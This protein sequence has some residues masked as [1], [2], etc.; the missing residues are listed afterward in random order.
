M[1]E[2]DYCTL[3]LG[4]QVRSVGRSVVSG[5]I[6]I[7]QSNLKASLLLQT[8]THIQDYSELSNESYDSFLAPFVAHRTPNSTVFCYIAYVCTWFKQ[9]TTLLYLNGHPILWALFI[10]DSYLGCQFEWLFVTHRR[11]EQDPTSRHQN[12]QN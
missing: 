5:F 9:S 3:H 6:L 2:S 1:H 11:L 7:S 10:S 8:H 12:L 4:D